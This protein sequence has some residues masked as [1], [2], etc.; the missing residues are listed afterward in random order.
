M[1]LSQW[2]DATQ[3]YPSRRRY[4]VPPSEA[5]LQQELSDAFPM[6]FRPFALLGQHSLRFFRLFDLLLCGPVRAVLCGGFLSVCVVLFFPFSLFVR[7]VLIVQILLGTSSISLFVYIVVVDLLR[8]YRKREK[9]DVADGLPPTDMDLDS[10]FTGFALFRS[11]GFSTASVIANSCAVSPGPN[12]PLDNA[13]FR[14]DNSS[15][16]LSTFDVKLADRTFS[17]R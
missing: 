6:R 16:M 1:R 9:D 15:L 17:I 11:L 14:R 13:F 12:F 2:E 3:T 7:V 5:V 8:P 4:G 10:T